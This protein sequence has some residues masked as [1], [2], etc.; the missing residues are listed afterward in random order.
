MQSQLMRCLHMQL[1]V[2]T[3][4]IIHQADAVLV[5]A[6]PPEKESLYPARLV[7]LVARALRGATLRLVLCKPLLWP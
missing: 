3:F 1:E 6:G 2:C 7:R 4:L 5:D